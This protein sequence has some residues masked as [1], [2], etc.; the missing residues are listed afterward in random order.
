MLKKKKNLYGLNYWCTI[1]IEM[2]ENIFNSLY[3]WNSTLIT[4][5]YS[6]LSFIL[7]IT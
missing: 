2:H 3:V 5:F 1:N 6:D 4:C 7:T